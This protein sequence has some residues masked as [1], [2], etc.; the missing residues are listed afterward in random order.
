MKTTW[1]DYR[2]TDIRLVAEVEIILECLHEVYGKEGE[3]LLE[4]K[5]VR[6]T[7]VYPFLKMLA[8]QCRGIE[9]EGVHKVLWEV[10]QNSSGKEDF[11][12]KAKI[13]VTP[14]CYERMR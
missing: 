1:K 14:Y 3:L 10:Y 5:K 12:E 6:N 11:L 9:P 2:K 7:M 4:N 13:I 8:S